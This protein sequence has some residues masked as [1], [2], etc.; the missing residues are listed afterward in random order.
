MK[1]RIRTGCVIT[2]LL[3]CLSACNRD[4]DIYLEEYEENTYK[5]QETERESS[6]TQSDG[7]ETA[8]FEDVT[9]NIMCYVYICGAVR[10]PGV[11]ALPE[12]SRI[13]EV[14]QMAGGLLED[15]DV[16]VVNQAEEITDGMMI[17]IYTIEQMDTIEETEALQVWNKAAENA[18]SNDDRIDINT[19]TVTELMTLP[20]IGNSK[21]NAII[22]YRET[23]GAFSCIEDLMKVPGIKDGIFQQMKEHIKVNN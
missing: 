7:T 16:T 22:D 18:Q 17:Q 21:A 19:A 2:I 13:Y 8:G 3:L 9:E 20:G 15:A 5:I 4:L 14:I 1:K 12:G 6:D 11:Y 10:Q 23:Y